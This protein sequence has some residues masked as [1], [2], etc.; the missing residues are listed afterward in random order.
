MYSLT[1]TRVASQRK[2]F[3]GRLALPTIGCQNR[4][5]IELTISVTPSIISQ[6]GTNSWLAFNPSEIA[7]S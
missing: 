3:I 7:W 5:R 2:F 1:A 6:G 4:C